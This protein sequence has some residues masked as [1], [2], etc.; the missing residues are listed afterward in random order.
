MDKPKPRILTLDVQ[1]AAYLGDWI[2]HY[3]K[4]VQ[5]LAAN[6][7]ATMPKGSNTQTRQEPSRGNL[8]YTASSHSR[9]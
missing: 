5:T 8:E 2:A 4:A 1:L 6:T 3:E 7:A 9:S